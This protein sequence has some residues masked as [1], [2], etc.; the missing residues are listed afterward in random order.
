MAR[1]TLLRVRR[2][3]P[4]FLQ[5]IARPGSGR[6]GEVVAS[7]LQS[8]V[9][10]DLAHARTLLAEIAA[11]ERGE[12]PQP[13]RVGNAFSI[14]IGGDGAAIRN[15]VLEGSLPERVSLGDLRT[16]LEIWIAAIER[17]RPVGS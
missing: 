7:F 16:A 1:S 5:G 3:R 9:Q 10:S 14:A 6:L 11:V 2:R 13:A 17:A 15:A 8:D 12:A 4:G